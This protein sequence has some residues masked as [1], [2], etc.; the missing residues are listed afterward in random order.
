MADDKSEV[1]SLRLSADLDGALKIVAERHG[2]TVSELVR[3]AAEDA[4]KMT[5]DALRERLAC[6]TCKGTGQR[7]KARE[8]ERG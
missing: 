3:M 7:F 8:V 1:L 2:I 5:P 4:I 6:P